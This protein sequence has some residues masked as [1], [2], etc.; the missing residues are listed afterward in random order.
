MIHEVW[1][2]MGSPSGLGKISAQI[3]ALR[4]S[5]MSHHAPTRASFPSKTQQGY[6]FY[7]KESIGVLKTRIGESWFSTFLAPLLLI[8]FKG[9]GPKWGISPTTAPFHSIFFAMIFFYY[10]Y[11]FWI[12]KCEI[13]P[14]GGEL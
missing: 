13:G 1:A 5:V 14:V 10:K 6:F 11:T 4:S 8:F 9:N 2:Q 12:K 7:V 3:L